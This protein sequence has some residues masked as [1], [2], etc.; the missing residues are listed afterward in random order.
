MQSIEVSQTDC[1]MHLNKYP[2]RSAWFY[3]KMSTPMAISYPAN[4]NILLLYVLQ[5]DT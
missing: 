3:I 1:S 2:I 5:E 4:I